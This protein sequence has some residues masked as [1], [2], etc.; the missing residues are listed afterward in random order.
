M[1][2]KRRTRPRL[3]RVP[4]R[5]LAEIPDSGGVVQVADASVI[6]DL[7]LTGWFDAELEALKPDDNTA[8]DHSE[9][10]VAYLRMSRT[11]VV[12]VTHAVS[13]LREEQC[14]RKP[15]SKSTGDG[16]LRVGLRVSMD[17]TEWHVHCLFCDENLNTLARRV[18]MN[19]AI[20]SRVTR[21][22]DEC[23]MRYLGDMGD[24]RG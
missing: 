3:N 10:Y 12:L 13:V 19:N 17:K 5:M 8:C 24:T 9:R 16:F 2:K 22:V 15:T 4:L 1:A 18:H 6:L 21:H 11:K 7:I 23:A 14:K 20:W